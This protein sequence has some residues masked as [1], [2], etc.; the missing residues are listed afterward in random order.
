MCDRL[1]FLRIGLIA[2]GGFLHAAAAHSASADAF[3]DARKS[4][5]EAYAHVTANLPDE[6]A[7]DSQALKSYPLYAYL[8]AARIRQALDGSPDSLAPVDQ[9]AA[10]FLAGHEQA[11]V[12]RGLRRDWLDSLARRSKWD[13]FVEAYRE[14]GATDAS[15]CQSFTARIELG[16]TAGLAADII[17]QWLAPRS[18]PECAR[19]F[20]WLNANGLLTPEL[21]EKRVRLALQS[22]NVAFARQIMQQLPADQLA[23]Y[24]QWAALLEHP[25]RS[26]DSLIAAP[27]LAVEPA[28]LLA[29]WTRLA[30]TNP[31]AAS[32]RYARL[33]SARG[34][35][36]ETGSPYALALALSLA[37]NH[38]PRAQEYFDLV[39]PPDFDDSAL[40]WRARAAIL[41]GDW[42]L[43]S[44][45]IGAMSETNRQTARWRYWAARA[46]AQLHDFSQAR[47]L[48]ESILGDDNYYSGMAAARLHRLVVPRLQAL[49]LDPELLASIERV[50]AMERAREL[51]LCGLRAEALGE[52][53]LAYGSLP[54]AGRLQSIHLAA[55][56]QWYDQ[57]ITVATSQQVFNDYVLL[58]S[59]PFDA[60]VEQAA[61]LAQL[62]PELIYAVLRQESLYRADA[63]S[64]ADARGLM[65]LQLD[66]A[67][68]T[69]RVWKQPR[70][71]LA[72]LFDPETNTRLGAAR[73]RTLLDQFDGQ[74]PLV[75]AAYNAGANAVMRWLPRHSMDSDV[76]I[77]NIPYGETRV[78]VQRILWHVLTFTCLR[79]REAQQ[80]ESWLSAIRPMQR[81]PDREFAHRPRSSLPLVTTAATR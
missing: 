9:R 52:W 75:L 68:R 38:D 33:M 60:Q 21:I 48:Y 32:E 70:P 10:A 50:P 54:E 72:D 81:T 36:H 58:Y 16:K 49:P 11:P 26:L 28:A 71:E 12:S 57:A 39:A 3:A 41:S 42:K 64:S 69:A 8:Q 7:A 5:Q 22:G 56:W 45:V 20:A 27:D 2:T 34:L 53:Q 43:A 14:A 67:R 59:R 6:S 63:V 76:W 55:N 30:R 24:V 4:F 62:S 80:T 31:S 18:L 61:H 78:Y 73:L 77:E 40:E 44:K 46:A 74:V 47:R 51:F 35:T 19:A 37:W 23:P 65:Q 66:T 79:S 13:L 15:R 1:C 17:K 25:Q 29:G